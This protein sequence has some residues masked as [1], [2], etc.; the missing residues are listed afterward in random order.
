MPDDAASGLTEEKIRSAGGQY[1]WPAG[2]L[3]QAG[4]VPYALDLR[5]RGRSEGERFYVEEDV[6][7]R[8]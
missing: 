4:C 7:P 2:Q 3:A 5:G 1:L 8:L 6:R